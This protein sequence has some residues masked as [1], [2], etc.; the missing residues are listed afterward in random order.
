MKPLLK[1]IQS[2]TYSSLQDRG[3]VGYRR[4]GMPTAGAMDKLAFEVGH[5]I[6]QN[7]QRGASLEIFYGGTS[8]EAI[9]SHEYVLTGANMQATVNGKELRPWRIFR[10]EK[11]DRLTLLYSQFG[12]I[13]YLT[14]KGGF[15]SPTVL[16][17]QST[18]EN[19]NLGQSLK[20]GG[21]LFGHEVVWSD[22]QRGLYTKFVPR[23]SKLVTVRVIPSHH[24]TLFEEV[25][26]N[27]FFNTSYILKRGDRMGYFLQ[28]EPLLLKEKTD[29]LSEPTMFGTIQIPPNGQP[30]VL[31]A[32]AQTV[33]GYPTMGK[34]RDVDLWKVAQLRYGDQLSFVKEDVECEAINRFKQ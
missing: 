22:R 28:G 29:I 30:I 12:A 26:I 24:L 11:G 1:V 14:A 8:F 27:A 32:D 21:I 2:G 23:Y 20:A 7:E 4:F 3:R 34:I 6:L 5:K 9:A 15:A 16:G 10:L 19:A 17:S 25:A 18:Y 31:M 33:G 13:S